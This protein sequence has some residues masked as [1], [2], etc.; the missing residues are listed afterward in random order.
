MDAPR[1]ALSPRL[2]RLRWNPDARASLANLQVEPAYEH[3]PLARPLPGDSAGRERLRIASADA[4]NLVPRDPRYFS[5][6][7]EAQWVASTPLYARYIPSYDIRGADGVNSLHEIEPFISRPTSK[8]HSDHVMHRVT[9]GKRTSPLLSYNSI[10]WNR[11]HY[12]PV[13]DVTRLVPPRSRGNM[14]LHRSNAS[15]TSVQSR[16]GSRSLSQS[17]YSSAMSA[18]APLSEDEREMAYL[19]GE[20]WPQ[21]QRTRAPPARLRHRPCSHS[22]RAASPPPSPCRARRIRA[23]R[24]GRPDR[25]GD[26]CARASTH[27]RRRHVQPAAGRRAHAG[28]HAAHA[29]DRHRQLMR[30][31]V[32]RAASRGGGAGGGH[33]GRK[34]GALEPRTAMGRT[35]C[36]SGLREGKT[37]WRA[38]AAPPTSAR[39]VEVINSY[40][41]VLLPVRTAQ[42][43]DSGVT[44][45]SS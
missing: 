2:R 25:A 45:K 7:R 4:L 12:E 33:G 10:G 15:L 38:P 43:R 35:T 6:H 28:A 42:T 1:H 17:G 26:V 40:T 23:I 19:E 41:H 18:I 21:R 30:R 37:D 22:D 16:P 20:D 8:P 5:P 13:P 34:R 9:L 29:V 27:R 44:S 24:N 39:F 11:R 3:F 32:A 31:C 14:S 36:T